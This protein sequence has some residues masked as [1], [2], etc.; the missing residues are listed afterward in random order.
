MQAVSGYAYFL[1]TVTEPA[2]VR[3][4]WHFPTVVAWLYTQLHGVIMDATEAQAISGNCVGTNQTG[5]LY[6]SGVTVQHQVTDTPTTIRSAITKLQNL[7]EW[8]TGIALNPTD[9]QNIDLLR[10]TSANGGFLTGGFEN[11]NGSFGGTSS[12]FLGTGAVR[13]VSRNVPA[14]VALLGDCDQV[15]LYYRDSMRVDLATTGGAGG[16]DLF[17]QNAFQLRAEVPVAVAIQRP[18]ALHCL[19]DVG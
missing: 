1:A 3:L 12:N 18:Q 5:V 16:T 2:P 15:V 4:L 10:W 9:A 6:Q 13:I 8:V 7:G 14:G 19:F 17:T 11:D